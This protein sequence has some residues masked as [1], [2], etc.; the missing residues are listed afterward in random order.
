MYK[1]ELVPFECEADELFINGVFELFRERPATDEGGALAALLRRQVTPMTGFKWAVVHLQVRVPVPVSYK[2]KI[3]SPFS[4][5]RKIR[6]GGAIE[7]AL[8][9]DISQQN[10][11]SRLRLP[12]GSKQ[13]RWRFELLKLL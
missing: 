2:H 13:I 9:N 4:I 5:K 10:A 3:N 11:L 7:R 6:M 1:C 12:F 8:P